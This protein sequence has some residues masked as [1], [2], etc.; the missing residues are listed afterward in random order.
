LQFE[1][2]V[3]EICVQTDTQTNIQADRQAHR[4]TSLPCQGRSKII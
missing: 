1:H 2:A 4:I 3:P